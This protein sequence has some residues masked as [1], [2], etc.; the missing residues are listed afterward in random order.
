VQ[1]SFFGCVTANQNKKQKRRHFFSKMA[2]IWLLE[3][4]LDSDTRKDAQQ[5]VRGCVL[6]CVYDS[7]AH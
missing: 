6:E 3:N 1:A 4:E 7:S 2:G 5:S